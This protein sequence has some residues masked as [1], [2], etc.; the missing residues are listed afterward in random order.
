MCA[1]LPLIFCISCLSSTSSGVRLYSRPPAFILWAL[2]SSKLRKGEQN[3]P[4][5]PG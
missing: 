4:S 2:P 5:G 3:A 1:H